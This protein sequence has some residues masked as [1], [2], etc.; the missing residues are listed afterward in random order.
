MKIC[1]TAGGQGLDAEVDPRFGRCRY[2]TI[3][4]M[5]TMESESVD[6]AGI[7]A[8]GGA[9]IQAGQFVAGKG[10]EVLLTG[11]VGPNAYDTLQAAGITIVTGVAGK[12]GEAVEG[13]KS[14]R[15]KPSTSGPSVK[16]HFGMGGGTASPSG[17]GSR[18]G[19]GMESGMGM[20]SGPVQSSEEGE[21]EALKEASRG[22]RSQLDNIMD[23]ID[24]LEGGVPSTE[25]RVT[26]I[27][28]IKETLKK[29]E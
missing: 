2:F 19:M 9:G 8:S 11:N 29:K 22:L 26:G 1:V 21:L 7:A 28:D 12:V 5:D 23:R 14:G 3:V 15:L 17:R 16:A 24:K 10:V 27:S 20:R 25:K 13:Y 18:P 4:D 6:N